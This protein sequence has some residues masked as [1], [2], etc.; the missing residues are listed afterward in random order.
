MANSYYQIATTPKL[1][2]SFPLFAYVNGV[3]PDHSSDQEELQETAANLIQLEPANA[4]FIDH[5][6]LYESYVLRYKI[7]RHGQTAMQNIKDIWNFDYIM[8][9][10]HNFNSTNTYP[11]IKSK[12]LAT[13][14]T[15][16]SMSNVINYNVESAPNYDGWS[17]MNIDDKPINND[18]NILEI[19]MN[20]EQT[21]PFYLGSIALTS[22]V[23]PAF[24][25]KPPP[26]DSVKPAKALAANPAIGFLANVVAILPAPNAPKPPAKPSIVPIVRP[27][28]KDVFL[29]FL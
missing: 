13:N 16:L 10:N 21:A 29:I 22:I 25:P 28:A 8:F 11:T 7:N 17:L 9:L 2:V 24:S 27:L 23:K 5:Q 15:P 20:Q 1:Y 4:N 19:T 14:E 6:N 3:L 12:S 18:E 26:A